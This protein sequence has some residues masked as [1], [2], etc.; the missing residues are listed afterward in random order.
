MQFFCKIDKKKKSKIKIFLGDYI[1]FL[2]LTCIY[3]IKYKSN[4][5]ENVFSKVVRLLITPEFL[6]TLQQN[7]TLISKLP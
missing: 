3:L 2:V 4:L 5:N 1:L 7:L 6:K